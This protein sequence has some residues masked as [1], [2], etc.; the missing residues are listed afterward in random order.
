MFNTVKNLYLSGK[1]SETGV[2][3]AVKKNW[4]TSEEADRILSMKR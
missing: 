3:N 1:L 2:R 4:I